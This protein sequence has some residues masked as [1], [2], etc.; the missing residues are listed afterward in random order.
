MTRPAL[1]EVCECNT[2]AA[3]C[4]HTII[5]RIVDALENLGDTQEDILEV[6]EKILREMP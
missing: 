3:R 6:L 5:E 4:L 1:T 2:H